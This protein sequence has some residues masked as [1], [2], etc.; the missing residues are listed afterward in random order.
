MGTGVSGRYC[1][2]L[3]RC[4]PKSSCAPTPL[5]LTPPGEWCDEIDQTL[6][7]GGYFREFIFFHKVSSTLILADTII[8]IELDKMS[9]PWRT[10]TKLSG[11]YYPHG[12][13]LFGMRVPFMLQPRKKKA[14]LMKIHSWHP[15]RILL[16]HGRCFESDGYEVIK[17]ILGA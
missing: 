17:R 11:M 9:E 13:V 7:P 14:T 3:S 12:Q 10:A 6:F 2:G 4:A 15:D 1:L 5:D 16:S 8:N